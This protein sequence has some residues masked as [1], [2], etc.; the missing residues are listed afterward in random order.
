[1]V[2]PRWSEATG[3]S[4]VV[5]VEVEVRVLFSD[6][7]ISSRFV[8]PSFTRYPIEFKGRFSGIVFLMPKLLLVSS[9]RSRSV[10]IFAFIIPTVFKV[11]SV[12]LVSGS[13]SCVLDRFHVPNFT[14]RVSDS[15]GAVA[16]ELWFG[17]VFMVGSRLWL[18]F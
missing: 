14:F 11:S 6:L 15:G 1:M 3:D 17:F 9:Y 16:F 4:F 8:V 10:W 7:L 5:Q 18:Q 13:S 12:V 2:S